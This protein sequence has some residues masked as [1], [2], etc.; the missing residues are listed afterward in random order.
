M[1]KIGG[2]CTKSFVPE[3]LI[4]PGYGKRYQ[5]TSMA[6]YYDHTVGYKNNLIFNFM[7]FNENLNN[8]GEKSE[9]N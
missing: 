7:N 4:H 2:V 3:L 9:K 8:Y 5:M 1:E 6:M